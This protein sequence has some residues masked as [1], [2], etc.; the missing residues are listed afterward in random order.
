M[1]YHFPHKL[2]NEEKMPMILNGEFYTYKFTNKYRNDCVYSSENIFC[3]L[4]NIIWLK[5][6]VQ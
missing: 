4:E 6:I 1:I 2:F 3:L 5:N